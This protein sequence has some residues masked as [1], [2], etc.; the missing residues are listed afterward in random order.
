[1]QHANEFISFGMREWFAA[2]CSRRPTLKQKILRQFW[3]AL[4]ANCTDQDIAPDE[5]LIDS[6]GLTAD[7]ELGII[8][9]VHC[10]YPEVPD[11]V[12]DDLGVDQETLYRRLRFA[13]EIDD[14]S[15]T[16]GE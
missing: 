16:D 12:L 6:V 3:D 14:D 9:K 11:E 4:I 1:M 2:E 13:L 10:C 5:L 7:G 8:F 15:S